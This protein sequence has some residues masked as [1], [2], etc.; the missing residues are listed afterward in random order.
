MFF[1]L[2]SFCLLATI[3]TAITPVPGTISVRLLPDN[4]ISDGIYQA[5]STVHYAIEFDGVPLDE[6]VHIGVEIRG[7]N[8][9]GGPRG[10]ITMIRG[11]TSIGNFIEETNNLL[12]FQLE[13]KEVFAG[14]SWFIRPYVF[15]A[16]ESL[17]ST[18]MMNS[19]ASTLLTVLKD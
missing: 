5:S 15:Y 14:Y 19:G 3:T 11:E 4:Q 6:N 18:N 16:N 9:A 17:V 2:V 1:S 13:P 10:Y 8:P 7:S 12:N